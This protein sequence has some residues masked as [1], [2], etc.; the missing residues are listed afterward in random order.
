MAKTGSAHSPYRSV[1]PREEGATGRS[2]SRGNN[3]LTINLIFKSSVS[4]SLL[5]LHP[6][7]YATTRSALAPEVSAEKLMP[8]RSSCK[9]R[10]K[11]HS[12]SER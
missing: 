9:K 1:P 8:P 4:D 3:A 7:Q 6:T 12:K 10:L 5:A 2:S 11:L